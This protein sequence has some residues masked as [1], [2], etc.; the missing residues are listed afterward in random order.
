MYTNAVEHMLCLGINQWDDLYPVSEDFEDDIQKRQLYIAKENSEIVAAY[1]I[2]EECDLEYKDGNWIYPDATY[3][4]IHRLCVNPKFQNQGYAKCMVNEIEEHVRSLEYDS[5]R[6]DVYSNNPY[7][8]K[9][10]EGLGYKRVGHVEFRKG[11]FYLYEKL[12]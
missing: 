12:V 1:V 2:N 10:Y 9:L 7:A 4:V 8:L 5:I 3:M 11:K 6:M